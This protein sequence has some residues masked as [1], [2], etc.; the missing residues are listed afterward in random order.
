VGTG[1]QEQAVLRAKRTIHI[2]CELE[3]GFMDVWWQREMV[4]GD[5]SLCWGRLV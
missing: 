1:G 2:V 3:A 4:V 5:D